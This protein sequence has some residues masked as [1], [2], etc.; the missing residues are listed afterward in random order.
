MSSA[1][2]V[3]FARLLLEQGLDLPLRQILA[4]LSLSDLRQLEQTSREW[5]RCL[6]D[7][8]VWRKQ[9]H[10][11]LIDGVS[12]MGERPPA[13]RTT[14]FAH[15]EPVD[16]VS[17]DRRHIIVATK[18]RVLAFDRVTMKQ[19]GRALIAFVAHR[20]AMNNRLLLLSE[21]RTGPHDI[22]W[23]FYC[24][25]GYYELKMAGEA[26]GAKLESPHG[27]RYELVE[28]SDLLVAESHGEICVW[29]FT[30]HWN[31]IHLHEKKVLAHKPLSGNWYT[32][33]RS[34]VVWSEAHVHVHDLVS[35]QLVWQRGNTMP[36]R[37][38]EHYFKNEYSLLP[39][40]HEM[41]VCHP[42]ILWKKQRPPPL[43]GC[44]L[45]LWNC[46]AVGNPAVA[47]LDTEGDFDITAVE[48]W[49]AHTAVFVTAA[50]VEM[51]A[52]HCFTLPRKEDINRLDP[53]NPEV[54]VLEGSA[55]VIDTTSK[56]FIK[57][58]VFLQYKKEHS[59]NEARLIM[60]EM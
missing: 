57:D 21:E 36:L 53:E 44:S 50:S 25:V 55:S 6:S 47:E 9:I 13:R 49:P 42:L 33:K 46:T 1:Q 15:E 3:N 48:A 29:K 28:D 4:C 10:R 20:A 39:S 11:R 17:C 45:V 16:A 12:A 5:R 14:L 32:T 2:S 31:R 24:R 7:A 19:E 51:R 34:L 22:K 38:F 52:L 56:M 18:S 41:T 54:K 43:S 37:A 40:F 59:F 26:G 60:C 35:A 23:H 30:L 58:G 27:A 8:V